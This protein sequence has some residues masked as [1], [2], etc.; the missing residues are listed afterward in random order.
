MRPL[1]R[2]FVCP[3][4]CVM[5]FTDLSFLFRFLPIFL[6]I[7]YFIRPKWRAAA[8]TAASLVFVA[9]TSPWSVPLLAGIV[10]VNYLLGL[11]IRRWGR[12]C[13]WAGVALN[14]ALLVAC[15]LI[16]L[17]LPGASYLLFSL[18]SYLSDIQRGE[19][20]APAP[21]LFAA[22]ASMF[23]R[24]VAGPIVR[25]GA[26]LPSLKEPK[27]TA[28]RLEK[29]LELLILGLGYK[30]LLA[31]SLSGLWSLAGKTGYDSMSTPMAWLCAVGFSLQL[32][33]DF[34]GC[35]LMAVG[36]GEML[37]FK[38]PENFNF[39]YLARSVSEFYRRW[40]I[41]L[42]A[43]FRDYVYIPLGGSRNGMPR[44]LLNLLAVWLLT[45]LW[46]GLGGNFLLWGLFLF[47]WIA[48]E[49]LGLRK[50]LDRF[51]VFAHL[52]LLLIIVLSWVIFAVETPGDLLV[53][54][55]RLFPFFSS[56]AAATAAGAGLW[57]NLIQYVPYL[58]CGVFFALPLGER[59]LRR[60]CHT[61]PV[62]LF[63]LAVFWVAIARLS[64]QS[65]TPFLYA[66]F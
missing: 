25:G 60:Y 54:A 66:G 10:A 12:L 6:V 57:R 42:G 56:G 2:E 27:C 47:F 48:L 51:P 34:H 37:G 36:L 21:C 30:V 23:P 49:K 28:R 55:S 40:H 19:L 64:T 9:F 5:S 24:L 39:P 29:G 41:T 62:R 15:R 63:L 11:G 31:D 8:L 35:S 61:W 14:V 38:L 53:Y 65:G 13:L 52:Y 59:T 44:T 17:P 33:F 45:G 22:Y 16:P 46:H 50:W 1:N 18:I 20:E 4:K 7:Y 32:Y 43:W 26:L 58:L 3:L